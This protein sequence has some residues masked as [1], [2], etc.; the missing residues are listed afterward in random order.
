MNPMSF[1]DPH[2]N[3]VEEAAL[4]MFTS[5]ATEFRS[6]SKDWT[7]EA[8]HSFV[9]SE[10]RVVSGCDDCDP[11]DSVVCLEIMCRR[12]CCTFHGGAPDHLVHSI[13]IEFQFRASKKYPMFWAV[14][15]SVGNFDPDME[16]APF[17]HFT[18]IVE[19]QV[20]QPDEVYLGEVRKKLDG[21]PMVLEHLSKDTTRWTKRE[22]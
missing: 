22:Y 13:S 20:E 4:E 11:F 15:G 18:E 17:E 19:S 5:F 8:Y 2:P 9:A 6:R 3:R 7:A 10:G 12:K 14:M 21:I 16:D 1:T